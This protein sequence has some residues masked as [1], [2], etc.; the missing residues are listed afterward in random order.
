LFWDNFWPGLWANTVAALV[1]VGVGVPIALR[2]D[3]ALRGQRETALRMA[4]VER[5]RQALEA[6]SA[7][8][9]GNLPFL[10][11]LSE[12]VRNRK[13]PLYIG[14]NAAVWDAVRPD[15]VGLGKDP[16]LQVDLATYFEDLSEMSRLQR[17]LIEST[18][19]VTAALEGSDKI[20]DQ[21][22]DVV[23]DAVKGL[24]DRSGQLLVEVDA[25]KKGLI[26]TQR[27]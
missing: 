9:E 3:R 20:R 22:L 16:K 4:D 10:E 17:H 19:G 12:A 25:K 2:I 24:L 13:V 8:I 6:V 23:R 7:A 1:G 21:L 18:V 5:L 14:L 26:P 15:I 11:S 27:P